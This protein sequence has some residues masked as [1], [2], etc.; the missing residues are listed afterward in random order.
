MC[1]MDIICYIEN[2]TDFRL[3]AEL[4]ANDNVKGFSISEGGAIQYNISKIPVYYNELESLCLIRLDDEE[5]EIFDSLT[6][7]RKIGT[8]EEGVYKFLSGGKT[9]YERVYTRDP[10]SF[11][12]PD[13]TESTYT[14]PYMIGVFA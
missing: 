14:P 5:L 12:A 2:L 11:I 4:K 10:I 8:C 7:I 9:I 13:E 3:E 1:K 6:T